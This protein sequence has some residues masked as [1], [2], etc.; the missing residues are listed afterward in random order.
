M[1]AHRRDL[2]DLAQ[3]L[4]AQQAALETARGAGKSGKNNYVG[5]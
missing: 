5:T 4:A 3:S 1:E 2:A